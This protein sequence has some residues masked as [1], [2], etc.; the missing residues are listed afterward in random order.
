M[1]ADELIY[2]VKLEQDAESFAEVEKALSKL[3][4][5][6]RG[7]GKADGGKGKDGAGNT[8][9]EITALQE[10]RKELKQNQE[11]L[12]EFQKSVREGTASSSEY[13]GA[14]SEITAR[15]AELRTQ[16]QDATRG[17]SDQETVLNSTATTYNQLAEQ[18]RA[19]S[20]VMRDV[21]L[22]DTT[23]KLKQ[24]QDQYAQNNAKL[25]EF[26]G[27]MGNF[28]RNVGDYENGLR[29]FAN[30]LA[31]IQGPLG[32]V[33]GRLNSLATLLSKYKVAAAAA[34]TQTGFLSKALLALSKTPVMI[35]LTAIAAILLAIKSSFSRSEEDANELSVSFA[36]L[37]AVG[38]LVGDT[39]SDL[40]KTS[41]KFLTLNFRE[42]SESAKDLGSNLLRFLSI[43]EEISLAGD[44][45]RQIND[46]KIIERGIEVIRA[47][48][49]RSLA[50]ARDLARDSNKPVEERLEAL[51]EVRRIEEETYKLEQKAAIDNLRAVD[52]Q[53]GQF[54]SLAEEEQALADAK[55]RLFDLE[56]S[57]FQNSMRMRRDENTLIRQARERDETILRAQF[58][59]RMTR[60]ET[61]LNRQ[62]A[63]LELEYKTAEAL[64]LKLENIGAGRAEKIKRLTE[65]LTSNEISLEKARQLA[66]AQ[67]D[68]D[69]ASEK[70]NAEQEIN[71]FRRSLAE[72][73]AQFEIEQEKLRNTLVN[74][75]KISAFRIARD[76]IGEIDFRLSRIDADKQIR[77]DEE[78]L[79]LRQNGFGQALSEEMALTKIN[80]ELAIERNS[81]EQERAEIL[82]ENA[83]S[84]EK[85]DREIALKRTEI[86]LAFEQDRL[87]RQGR[88]VE[89]ALLNELDKEEL[90]KKLKAQFQAEFI[91][92]GMEAT[93]AGLQAEEMA[94]LE[95]SKRIKENE[96]I[97]ADA[98][99]Q[100]RLNMAKQITS[101]LEAINNAFF[102]ESKEISV[103][104]A[105]IDAIAGA[106]SAFTETK[107]G[108]FGK[109]AAAAAALAMGYANVKKILAVK[110]G[111]KSTS[112][113]RMSAPKVSSSFG[114]VDVG[115]NRQPF[116]EAMATGA[117]AG[118]GNGTPTIVLAGEFDPAFLAVKVTMGNNQISSQGTG[119]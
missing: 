31:V 19:L 55:I 102:N 12:A 4:K 93:R 24:L 106:N 41:R 101:G 27:S 117:T 28:Q 35:A 53:V 74:N 68:A 47:S 30:G 22:D 59:A 118:A 9:K 2:K 16:V 90:K 76:K 115:T 14:Q 45:Q 71:L 99:L 80:N 73:T 75:E 20:I 78:V 44:T 88:F 49:S 6:A 60:A 82:A 86:E 98:E 7:A 108:I 1:S 50:E 87:N 119:F 104:K 114:L 63:N 67:V 34:T 36:K 39:F 62:L 18:N 15:I 8:E 94:E 52:A 69:I 38:S 65:Q 3:E 72:S 33:A 97:L 32:P 77:I 29:S 89:A 105:I 83:R 40:G 37:K 54:K 56:T 66:T 25:K 95:S 81:I 103:A 113:A 70:Q 107:A 112:S 57:H 17:Y 5:K 51:K 110:K 85:F 64:Q 13:A 84:A 111:T 61:A 26:D 92:G 96:Q 43:G 11:A 46:L 91:E 116:A 42:A 21:P 100:Q 10:L 48:T 79:K 58:D 109:S 23:G